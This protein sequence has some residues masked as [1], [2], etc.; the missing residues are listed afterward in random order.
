MSQSYSFLEET[1]AEN[2]GYRI[3]NTVLAISV[4]C[5]MH[6]WRASVLKFYLQLNDLY[7]M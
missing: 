7:S 1:A 5:V 4:F 3:N 2:S 6:F